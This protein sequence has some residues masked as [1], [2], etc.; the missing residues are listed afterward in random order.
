MQI[1]PPHPKIKISDA[2]RDICDLYKSIYR[3][4]SE[5]LLFVHKIIH[6]TE[7]KL[8]G[9]YN[10]KENVNRRFPPGRNTRRNCG[11]QP[12]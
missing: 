7:I 5:H 9:E 11:W 1:S 12:S 3:N 10:G 2:V 6:L 8:I 4:L